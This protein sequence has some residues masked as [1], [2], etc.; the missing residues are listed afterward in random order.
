MKI[1][2]PARDLL[3]KLYENGI[4]WPESASDLPKHL[5]AIEAELSAAR[6]NYG[7]LGL[8]IGIVATFCC[9]LPLLP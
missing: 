1:S 7:L 8:L 5:E 4:A 2:T 3:R 6:V 9:L